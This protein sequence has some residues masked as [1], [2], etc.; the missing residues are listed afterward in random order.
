MNHGTI[1]SS[2]IISHQENNPTLQSEIDELQNKLSKLAKQHN[3]PLPPLQS[4]QTIE[5]QSLFPE[6]LNT[7]SMINI[8]R[9]VDL[10][11]ANNLN[12]DEFSRIIV[13]LFV[14]MGIPLGSLNE[15]SDDTKHNSD[16]DGLRVGG[17]LASLS[18]ST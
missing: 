2:Q 16:E 18:S 4:Q 17:A 3:P 10:K 6:D 1:Q 13:Q 5:I 12:R 15:R 9:L 7:R 11:N 14:E 8:R